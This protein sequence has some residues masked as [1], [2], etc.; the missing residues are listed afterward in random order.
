MEKID[1]PRRIRRTTTDPSVG[2]AW[3]PYCGAVPGI[4]CRPRGHS[5]GPYTEP[6]H[7][8]VELAERIDRGGSKKEDGSLCFEEMLHWGKGWDKLAAKLSI[9]N[10]LRIVVFF[11]AIAMIISP[12]FRKKW[13]GILPWGTYKPRK[14]K[15]VR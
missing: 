14:K 2:K 10:K 4:P 7:S 6:H 3:C 9:R 1:R 8:R 13:K 12:S 11:Q 5:I 15:E